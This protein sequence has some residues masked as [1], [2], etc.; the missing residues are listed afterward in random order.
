MCQTAI[1][2]SDSLFSLCSQA[3]GVKRRELLAAGVSAT[4]LGAV[5]ASAA[6]E[7]ASDTAD[8]ETP[9]WP[10]ARAGGDDTAADDE[11]DAASAGEPAPGGGGGETTLE[12]VSK[13]LGDTDVHLH[14]RRQ[15]DREVVHDRVRTFAYGERAHLTGLCDES[16][17]YE[18]TLSIDGAMLVRETLRPGETAI[19]EIRDDATVFAVE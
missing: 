3:I 18:F 6:A 1:C 5:A 13:A 8:R 9:T 4:C 16:E 17:T 19:F 11:T 7:F 10:A 14:L 12:I 15:R 2:A